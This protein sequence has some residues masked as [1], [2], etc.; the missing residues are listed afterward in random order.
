[1]EVKDVKA[2]TH[3]VLVGFFFTL[4][5]RSGVVRLLLSG[6]Y[7]HNECRII[8]AITDRDSA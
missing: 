3:R 8:L 2:F 6:G 1:V 4:P 5:S 7:T